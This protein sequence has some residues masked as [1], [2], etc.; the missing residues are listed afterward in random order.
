[1]TSDSKTPF[2]AATT[3]WVDI[4]KPAW[5]LALLVGVLAIVLEL[6]DQFLGIRSIAVTI[7]GSVPL[8]LGWIAAVY[9]G[10][11]GILHKVP[12]RAGFGLFFATTIA[13]AAPITITLFVIILSPPLLSKDAKLSILVVGAAINWL[14]GALLPAWP[15]VNAL[16][17]RMA[18][19]IDILRATRGHR[20]SLAGLAFL[21][22]GISNVDPLPKMETTHSLAIAML[23][24][25]GDTL[26]ELVSFGLICGIAAAAWQFATQNDPKLAK[27]R[28]PH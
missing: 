9:L 1:M 8:I 27:N 20:A 25:V 4:P 7:I 16:A 17:E 11:L 19:P 26:L 24:G 23:I 2:E 18:S 15:T 21:T 28:G 22:V 13:L 3:A 12:S 14:F 6:A 5:L 10:T